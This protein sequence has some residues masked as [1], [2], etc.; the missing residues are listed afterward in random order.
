MVRQWPVPAGSRVLEL[1]SVGSEG[2]EVAVEILY[3]FS[4]A[5]VAKSDPSKF[6]LLFSLESLLL[7]HDAGGVTVDVDRFH[8]SGS[9]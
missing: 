2:Y 1:D 9:C 7:M 8:P 6:T 3:L 4:S 5:L